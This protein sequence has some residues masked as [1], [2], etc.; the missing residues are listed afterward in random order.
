MKTPV[1]SVCEIETSI[2]Y[3]KCKKCK[4]LF[5]SK[6]CQKQHKCVSEIHQ[7]RRERENDNK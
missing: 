7:R 4:K 3:I 2:Y 5:C 6:H 1:C